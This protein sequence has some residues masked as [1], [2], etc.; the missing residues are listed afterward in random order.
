[1]FLQVNFNSVSEMSLRLWMFCFDHFQFHLFCECSVSLHFH[2]VLLV[3]VS[4]V[5]TVVPVV[6]VQCMTLCYDYQG[7]MTSLDNSH[8]ALS[9]STLAPHP[10]LATRILNY[11]SIQY[12]A[13]GLY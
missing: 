5:M 3:I 7:S 9:L 12:M 6:T 4:I 8:S 2:F 13:C 1:M 11:I 10:L